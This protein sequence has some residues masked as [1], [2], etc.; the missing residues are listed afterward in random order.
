MA[1]STLS[2]T[3]LLQRAALSCAAF[4]LVACSTTLNTNYDAH[5]SEEGLPTFFEKDAPLAPQMPKRVKWYVE[6]SGSMNGFFRANQPTNFKTDLWRALQQF[7]PQAQTVN[8]LT[9]TGE[10]GE[11]LSLHN[12]QTAMNTGNFVSGASTQLPL[13]LRTITQQLPKKGG[14]V[15]ILVSDMKYSPEGAAAP[16]VLM[17]QYSTDV[18]QLLQQSGCATSLICA[19]SAYLDKSGTDIASARSP[20][21]YLLL[22]APAEVTAV[23][24]SLSALLQEQGSLVDNIDGDFFQQRPSAVFGIPTRCEQKDNLPTFTSYEDEDGTDMCSLPL[25]IDL[26][27]YRWLLRNE[28]ALRKA[29]RVKALYGSAVSL[30]NITISTNDTDI[31]NA[32]AHAPETSTATVGHNSLPSARAMATVELRLAHM[33]TESEVLEWTLSLPLEDVSRM[34][35]FFDG[36]VSEADATKS[37]SVPDFLRGVQQSGKGNAMLPA[38]YILVSRGK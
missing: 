31:D 18:A 10:T 28:G 29:F 23:R 37:F 32:F 24:N 5:F 25:H 3:H 13:M 12:F 30:G 33:P 7:A 4:C 14:E 9:D 26:S 36:A 34:K 22:G 15:A 21:Y 35:P 8:I 20:Y 16:A 2:F 17:A 38:N 19:T 27:P 11:T 1:H 6:V